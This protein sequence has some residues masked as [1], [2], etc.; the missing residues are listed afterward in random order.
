M[1]KKRFEKNLGNNIA[2]IGM[3]TD[4]E[5]HLQI[6]WFIILL[7]SC[8][9]SLPLVSSLLFLNF[10]HGRFVIKPSETFLIIEGS[11]DLIYETL[12]V[13]KVWNRAICTV[14]CYSH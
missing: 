6:L 5:D 8:L 7:W 12:F 4:F 3:L 2:S 13:K 1:N 9:E 10:C 14:E 11:S